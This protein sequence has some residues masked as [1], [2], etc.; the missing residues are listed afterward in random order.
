[1]RNLWVD[2]AK[3][4]GI[5]LVVYGHVA[6]GLFSA[7]IQMDE[8]TFKTIDSIIY[9]F[10]M[11]LFFFLSGIFFYQSLVRRGAE[12]VFFNKIDL[13]IY[14]YI[15]WSIFQGF[16]EVL[17]GKWTNGHTTYGEV[18][19]LFWH[20]R[21]QFWFL[22][23]I[24]FIFLFGI[25]IYSFVG[26]KYFPIL[27]LIFA[28]P[29][30][31]KIKSFGFLPLFYVMENFYYFALGVFF[32]EIKNG[33]FK[34]KNYF[35]PLISLLFVLSQYLFHFVFELN[36]TSRGLPI[37]FVSNISIAFIV[38]AC[39]FLGEKNKE[40]KFL[41]LVGTCSM[42]IFLVH[43]LISSGVR[44]LLS[45]ILHVENLELHIMLGTV[46]GISVPV[47]IYK[48]SF[49]Y[50]FSFIFEIPSRFSLENLFQSRKIKC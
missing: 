21:M 28:I 23:A 27:L 18:L 47:L 38:L 36:Y 31:F 35:F 10:H 26:K 1:M 25:F 20:P 39:M 24:F 15:I 45:K 29:C 8:Y 44:I 30:V 13:I 9:S 7:H 46:L 5:I 4:I 40:I 32:N 33:I 41:S 14:P 19:E 3:A 16:I 49:R 2:Y 22:Y 50:N 6:R 48:L 17:L 12:N 34:Y 11:P 37:F 43:T 42:A